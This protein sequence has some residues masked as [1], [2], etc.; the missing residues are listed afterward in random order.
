MVTATGLTRQ[1]REVPGSL[2]SAAPPRLRAAS[3]L[4]PGRVEAIIYFESI[5]IVTKKFETENHVFKLF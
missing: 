4:M 2:V 5:P 1:V 3:P